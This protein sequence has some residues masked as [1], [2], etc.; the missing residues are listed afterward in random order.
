MVGGRNYRQLE[1]LQ[2]NRETTANCRKLEKLQ[3]TKRTS[4]NWSDDNQVKLHQPM[5]PAAANQ[6][7]YSNYSKTIVEKTENK[8][9]RQ[10]DIRH[11]TDTQPIWILD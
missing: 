7:N 1:K 3:V 8:F 5:G 4:D 2:S 6:S 11:Q 10:G 9:A